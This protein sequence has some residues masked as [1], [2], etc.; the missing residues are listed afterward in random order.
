MKPPAASTI[1]NPAKLPRGLQPLKVRG[2]PVS[3]AAAVVDGGRTVRV[4][5][6][7]T[8]RAVNQAFS[9]LGK[10]YGVAATG[11]DKYGCLGAARVAWQPY[12]TLPNL[13]GKVYPNYQKP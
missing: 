11:P 5:P 7:E 12:T 3:G 13:V 6:A 10:P 2:R 4:L 9:L 8:I 1:K